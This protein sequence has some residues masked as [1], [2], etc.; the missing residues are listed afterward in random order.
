MTLTEVMNLFEINVA[1]MESLMPSEQTS[2]DK[3]NLA[4]AVMIG[5]HWRKYGRR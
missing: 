3:L 2:R 4:E 5:G 1:G